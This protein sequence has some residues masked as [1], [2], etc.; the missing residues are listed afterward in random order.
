MLDGLVATFNFLRASVFYVHV[1]NL[2]WVPHTLCATHGVNKSAIA[3]WLDLGHARARH[4]ARASRAAAAARCA[5]RR[6]AARRDARVAAGGGEGRARRDDRRDAGGRHRLPRATSSQSSRWS[7]CARG[8]EVRRRRHRDALCSR[9]TIVAMHFRAGGIV[10]SHMFRGRWIEPEWYIATVRRILCLL[11][12]RD[13]GD[14]DT[15]SGSFRRGRAP[16]PHFV[17]LRNRRPRSQGP[18]RLGRRRPRQT[19]TAAATR[20]VAAHSSF[21]L[22]AATYSDGVKLIQPLKHKHLRHSPGITRKLHVDSSGEFDADDFLEL[23][24]RGDRQGAR[25]LVPPRANA[26]RG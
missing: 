14:R 6:R 10:G 5:R 18:P 15:G 11:A 19:S 8:S 1:G 26:S 13:G 12:R 21:S 2:T 24:A 9:A 22:L 17:T 23:C 3:D 7:P 4:A 20:L 25:R 16:T